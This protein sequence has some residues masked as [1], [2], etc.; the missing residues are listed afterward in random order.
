MLIID[1]QSQ[2][3]NNELN[4]HL[5]GVQKYLSILIEPTSKN[6][7]MFEYTSYKIQILDNTP[8]GTI[9]LSLRYKTGQKELSNPNVL[10]FK[11]EQQSNIQIDSYFG[12]KYLASLN[13]LNIV[14]KS[15]PIP[16]DKPDMS[17]IIRI[18]DKITTLS[19]YSTINIKLLAS[20]SYFLT[21]Y[22]TFVSP[23]NAS[24]LITLNRMNLNNNTII[25]RFTTTNPNGNSFI[26]YRILNK[27][28]SDRFYIEKNCLKIIYP[29]PFDLTT[30]ANKRFSYLVS[31]FLLLF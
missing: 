20:N 24:Y 21:T 26:V 9:V 10:D 25:F 22:P 29:I 15:S 23:L 18:A 14:I 6:V 4:R 17:F 28:T 2:Y 31:I 8:T 13:V 7:P 11:I 30:A 27:D 3:Y 5:N 19:S 1:S 16:N 12:L